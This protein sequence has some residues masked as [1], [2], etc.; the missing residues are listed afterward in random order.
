[1]GSLKVV[2]VRRAN[3]NRLKCNSIRMNLFDRLAR[4]VKVSD[5]D[6]TIALFDIC[7]CYMFNLT[8]LCVHKLQ[9]TFFL[10]SSPMQ[11]QS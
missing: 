5:S 9:L 7:M 1:M 8:L 3:V 4:V 11:M 6:F 10:F 2:P